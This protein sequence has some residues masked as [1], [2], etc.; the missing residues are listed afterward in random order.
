MSIKVIAAFYCGF[1]SIYQNIY[2]LL[3]ISMSIIIII[4]IL[5]GVISY[6]LN[7]IKKISSLIYKRSFH[8]FHIR[9]MQIRDLIINN[10]W[11]IVQLVSQLFFSP[12]FFLQKTRSTKQQHT[13][14]RIFIYLFHII[15]WSMVVVVH[16]D[17]DDDVFFLFSQM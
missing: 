7:S 8:L 11:P 12:S 14:S 3:S 2:Y 13:R 5:Y 9:F 16:V 10:K 17:V 4:I 1:Y 6:N 15:K